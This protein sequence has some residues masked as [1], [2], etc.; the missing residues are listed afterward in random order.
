[1]VHAFISSSRFND[2]IKTFKLNIIQKLIPGLNKPG[3]E[4]NSGSTSATSAPAPRQPRHADPPHATNDPYH[5]NVG[6]SDL[7]PARGGLRGP[8]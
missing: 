3:Y 8:G 7:Y 1:M 2:F 4:D 6:G 5:H